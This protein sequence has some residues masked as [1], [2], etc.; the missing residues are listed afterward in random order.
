MRKE[1]EEARLRAEVEEERRVELERQAALAKV[2]ELVSVVIIC[3]LMK[4][5]SHTM[6]ALERHVWI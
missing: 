5:R 4:Y 3:T 2:K 6:N 1:E